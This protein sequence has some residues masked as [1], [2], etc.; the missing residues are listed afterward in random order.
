MLLNLDVESPPSVSE[1]PS[2]ALAI[3]AI[4]QTF[5]IQNLKARVRACEPGYHVAPLF[6]NR[7]AGAGRAKQFKRLSPVKLLIRRVAL[8]PDEKGRQALYLTSSAWK[9]SLC[10]GAYLKVFGARVS[11]KPTPPYTIPLCRHWQRTN[12]RSE[13]RML[14][15]LQTVRGRKFRTAKSC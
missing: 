1:P 7:G 3:A 6:V 9:A 13:W 15:G 4:S 12:S 2:A 10:L 8:R 14:L 11:A 5:Q